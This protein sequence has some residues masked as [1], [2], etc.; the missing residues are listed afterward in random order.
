MMPDEGHLQSQAEATAPW[1]D[2]DFVYAQ[3]TRP[4]RGGVLSERGLADPK[5][6][7][8]RLRAD[9]R[10]IRWQLHWAV[11]DLVSARAWGRTEATE[12]QRLRD[13]LSEV[14]ALLTPEQRAE[15]LVRDQVRKLAPE[16]T[17]APRV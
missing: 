9:A 8:A 6:S 16:L 15:M 17:E 2:Y 3:F 10:A 4:Y 12:A 7:R 1:T 14:F 13:R 11:R 5:V